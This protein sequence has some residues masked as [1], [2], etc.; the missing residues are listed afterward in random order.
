MSIYFNFF[1]PR[2]AQ[3]AD[4]DKAIHSSG[5]ALIRSDK[6]LSSHL[7]RMIININEC[8]LKSAYDIAQL[9]ASNNLQYLQDLDQNIVKEQKRLDNRVV[10]DEPDLKDQTTK[11]LNVD[12]VIVGEAAM[13]H[14]PFEKLRRLKF[15]KLIVSTY[16]LFDRACETDFHRRRANKFFFSEFEKISQSFKNGDMQHLRNLLV[17]TLCTLKLLKKSAHDG[18]PNLR[19]YIRYIHALEEAMIEHEQSKEKKEL[20]FRRACMTMLKPIAFPD[21]VLK[22]PCDC[23]QDKKPLEERLIGNSSMEQLRAVQNYARDLK[24]AREKCKNN[25]GDEH[26]ECDCDDCC[27][28]QNP[29][30]IELKSYVMDLMV[31]RETL[32]NYEPGEIAHIQN[33]MAGETIERTHEIV[34]ET[35]NYSENEATTSREEENEF[36]KSERFEM[37]DAVQKTVAQALSADAGIT[38]S[39]TYGPAGTYTATANVAYARASTEAKQ[40]A[41]NYAKEITERSLMRIQEDTRKLSTRRI[42]QRVTES[43]VHKFEGGSEHVIGQYY[44]VNKRT[45][46]Q[47]MNWGKRM[48]YE[49]VIPEPARLYKSLMASKTKP[50]FIGILPPLEASFNIQDISRDPDSPL[51]Y[52]NLQKKYGIDS[53]MLPPNNEI[54]DHFDFTVKVHNAASISMGTVPEGYMLYSAEIDFWGTE[55]CMLFFAGH[56]WASGYNNLSARVDIIPPKDGVLTGTITNFHDEDAHFNTKVD[57]GGAG[58]IICR[59]LPE[60]ENAW[61]QEVFSAVLQKVEES[62]RAYNDAQITAKE[63]VFNP[64]YGRN[65][66]L[67]REIERTQLWQLIVSMLSCQHFD[68]FDAMK[69]RI[70]PCGYPQLDFQE[71]KDE[72]AFIQFFEQVY[73]V[74]QMMYLFYPYFWSQKCEWPKQFD[75]DSGD[76]LFDKFLAS[77]AARVTIPV[78]PGM[79]ALAL[80]YEQYGEIWMGEGEPDYDPESPHF[81]AMYEE[82]KSRSGNFQQDRP[83][84][85]DVDFDYNDQLG[86]QVQDTQGISD[87]YDK[88]KVAVHGTDFWWDWD[89]QTGNAGAIDDLK[90]EADIDREIIIARKSYRIVDIQIDEG[91]YNG[92]MNVPTSTVQQNDL[93]FIKSMRWIITLEREVEAA[94]CADKPNP[95]T[96]IKYAVGAVYVGAEWDN[97]IP[98]SQVWLRPQGDDGYSNCLPCYPVRC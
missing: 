86:N 43:N 10:K 48:M 20:S 49:F 72:G 58:R 89:D 15:L 8:D 11:G 2:H 16:E 42:L 87:G 24:L 61:K 46:S 27:I 95:M 75:Q 98:T 22:T 64:Q 6:D 85:L 76:A 7:K 14:E 1:I 68:R 35:E 82:I 12:T 57:A 41:R 66:F 23:L 74:Q 45:V 96:N 52:L 25:K 91:S 80:H 51:Y 77:G 30:C 17:E 34:K 26:C 83:G 55:K 62:Q 44:W 92:Q 5:I 59:L 81:L 31:V 36:A 70:Q 56:H 53:L 97:V 63:N 54:V 88:T 71:A 79:E 40:T 78:R 37:Q 28:P 33:V 4:K 90:I 29:C 69:Q 94:Y 47:V 39:G 60:T 93:E 3:K 13:M 50:D 65:P 67:N 38:A 18:L 9:R 84:L 19:S 73:E 32:E 21:W